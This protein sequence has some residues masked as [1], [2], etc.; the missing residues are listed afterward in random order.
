MGRPGG[1]GGTGPGGPRILNP[2]TGLLVE[3]TE[4]DGKGGGNPAVGYQDYTLRRVDIH[5]VAE[6]PRIA[7]DNVTI[8]DSYIHDL[9]QVGDN[10]TDAV[11]MTAGAHIVVR[12][13]TLEVDNLAAGSLGNAAFQFG[14]EQGP[15]SDCLVAGNFLDG[16]NYTVNGGGGGT[17]NAACTFRGNV[18]GSHSRYGPVAHLGPSVAWDSSN[19]W[20][21]TGQ[22]VG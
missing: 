2:G 3:D 15:V 6:G 17:R 18:F 4:L 13:N 22:P 7:G 5:D 19:V 20:E 10:H 14:E 11:Q 12:N 1:A 8:E 16:G 21:A 9:V